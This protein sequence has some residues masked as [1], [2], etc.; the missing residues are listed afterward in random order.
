MIVESDWY[1]Y[2]YTLIQMP[3]TDV[4]DGPNLRDPASKGRNTEAA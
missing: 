4:F 3:V 1:M 2:V